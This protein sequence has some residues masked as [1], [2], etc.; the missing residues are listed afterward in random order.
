MTVMSFILFRERKV[1]MATQERL[2]ARDPRDP[3]E[4][5][6]LQVLRDQ[7]DLTEWTVGMVTQERWENPAML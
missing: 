5:K 1:T 2:V 3:P 6:D 7:L 4:S